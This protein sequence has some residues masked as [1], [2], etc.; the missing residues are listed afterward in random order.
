MSQGWN[1]GGAYDREQAWDIVCE[2]TQSDSLR[3]H[4]LAVEASMRGLARRYGEDED[5]WG[6]VGLLHDFD[7]E[8]HPDP[9]DHA[10]AGGRILRERGWPD[11][12]IHAIESHNDAV[13]VLRESLLE[14]ALFSADELTGFIVALALVKGRDL[15]LVEPRSVHKKLKDRGFARKVSREDV[16]KGWREMGV[17][18]DEHISFLV[19]ALKPAAASI[20][21]FYSS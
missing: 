9:L 1:P 19:E 20:D 4:M 3:K 5:L 15:S 13:Q 14:H 2:Y 8:T 18:P 17:D 11:V 16:E 12:V 21:L 6:V 7:Y 10:L